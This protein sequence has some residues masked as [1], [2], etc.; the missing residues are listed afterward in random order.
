MNKV[1]LKV[2]A[3]CGKSLWKTAVNLAI[4]AV[5][6]LTSDC[7]TIKN[8]GM[9]HYHSSVTSST[10]TEF[11]LAYDSAVVL[12]QSK[13]ATITSVNGLIIDGVECSE[14][15]F[16]SANAARFRKGLVA[17]VLPGVHKISMTRMANDKA[18]T[19]TPIEYNF[20]AGKIYNF[21]TE[22]NTNSILSLTSGSFGKPNIYNYSGDVDGG[23]VTIYEN[24]E[25]EVAEKIA[26][27][28]HS[29]VFKAK[30]R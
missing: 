16:R 30:K 21:H 7:S 22:V 18:V 4:A 3:M 23:A 20:E 15:N 25:S 29:L 24:K 14:E 5:I 17:D 8:V 12:D 28:R 26:A 2:S 11:Y 19:M 27:N 1:N 9:K 6:F 13:V 10:D